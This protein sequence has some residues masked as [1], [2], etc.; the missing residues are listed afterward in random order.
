MSLELSIP[1]QHNNGLRSGSAS[2]LATPKSPMMNPTRTVAIIK[3]HALDHR[4]EIEHRIAESSFEIV[5]ERQMEFDVETDPDTLFE[6]FGEDAASFAEG[7]VWVYVLE[8]RRAIEVWQTLMGDTDPAVATQQSP[9]SLRAL[10]GLSKSQNAVM[11][12]PD[13]ETAEI[14]IASLFV[15]SPPFPA[16]EFPQPDDLSIHNL[17]IANAQANGLE[18]I[19]AASEHGGYAQSSAKSGRSSTANESGKSAFRA[20][21]IPSTHAVPSI[22][23]RTTHAADLRAG[24]LSDKSDRE[25]GPRVAPTRE[26]MKQIF[27]DVPGHK[28]SETIAVASTAPPVVAPR[29]TRAA[30]LRLG[31]KP[32]PSPRRPKTADV[33]A[34]KATFDGV[35]GHK[36][37]ESIAVASTKAP[38]VAPR[39]NK[40]A[41]LRQTKDAAPPSSFMFRGPSTQRHPTL[42]RSSSQTQL[43][44]RPPSAQSVT[45]PSSTSRRTPS[46]TASNPPPRPASSAGR[47]TRPPSSAAAASPTPAKPRP[48]P[49]SLQAPAMAP[50][51]NKS[52]MLRAAKMA[53][54]P[55]ST[56]KPVFV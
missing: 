27:M 14:Q 15:S 40:S 39:L 5:K 28:R 35:P 10:Y 45:S 8:R 22:A 7:P 48:R 33:N 21:S 18:R 16:T 53:G 3:H 23:P 32:A 20:R 17:D 1:T 9:R 52:A 24:I 26:E 4:F 25:R 47:S 49:T 43:S 31:Q 11:G 38:T 2:P 6:L 13:T 56:K 19:P 34:D 46:R 51:Q 44:S 12:S 30:S 54:T 29:M 37:R 55:T 42:S 50:R 36:R 41:A